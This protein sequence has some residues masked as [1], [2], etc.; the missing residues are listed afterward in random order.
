MKNRPG[1]KLWTR[2]AALVLAL[3]LCGAWTPSARAGGPREITMRVGETRTVYAP[4]TTMETNN[5][6]WSS[7]SS[8]VRVSGSGYSCTATAVQATNL[9]VLLTHHY[10]KKLSSGIS[11]PYTQD[12]RVK[13]LPPL[14]QSVSLYPGSV[15]L[16]AGEGRQLTASVSPEG[17][18]YG[19][20][21]WSSDDTSV[22]TVTSGGYVRAV[23]PGTTWINVRT[24]MEG[25]EDYCR[26]TVQ[27]QRYK[28]TFDPGEGSV[29]PSSR[30]VT[31]GEPYGE[32]PVPVREGY[33]FR[34]WYTKA[35]GGE[36]AS[37]E[38]P[39]EKSHTL[40]ARWRLKGLD[41][42]ARYM[43]QSGAEEDGGFYMEGAYGGKGAGTARIIYKE[44]SGQPAS[45]TFLYTMRDGT[46]S[47]DV[48]LSLAE[49]AETAGV[50]AAFSGSQNGE[51][52]TF[53]CEGTLAA[54][55]YDGKAA[56]DF[57][58]I[59]GYE[60]PSDYN[61][62]SNAGLDAAAAAWELLLAE[63]AGLSLRDLGFVSYQ[64]GQENPPPALIVASGS[65]GTGVTWSLDS[66]G[67]LEIA[68][69]GVMTN[70]AMGEAPWYG[71]RESVK[72][73]KTGGVRNIGD[74]AFYGCGELTEAEVSDGASLVGKHAFDG[75]G[76]LREVSLPSGLTGIGDHAFDSAGLAELTVPSTVSV[77]GE[78]A[79]YHC[80]GLSDVTVEDGV[81]SI[82]S[83]AFCGCGN[84]PG[85]VLPDSVRELGAYAFKDCGALSEAALS[86][87]ILYLNDGVFQDCVLLRSIH[88]PEGVREIGRAGLDGAFSGCT[89]LAAASIPRSVTAIGAGSFHN[90]WNLQIHYSGTKAEWETV[91]ID[92]GEN[93]EIDP[94]AVTYGGS[95]VPG[96][97]TV[98]SWKGNQAVFYGPLDAGASLF[99]VR[100]DGAG[101]MVRIASGMAEGNTVTFRNITLAAKDQIFVLSGEGM[102]PQAS[103]AILE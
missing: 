4:I 72:A 54:A 20:Y 37:A 34:G 76:R 44:V 2:L 25:K 74:Y 51:A 90:C 3:A 94:A 46:A 91:K 92:Y 29:S 26:V 22:A 31:G 27:A 14:P 101:R 7:N 77:I 32:L 68:G 30:T 63:K 9:T 49:N 1:R 23:G 59:D 86:K 78:F 43:E 98:Q 84:L 83:S 65:C 70:Y 67:L 40:Y 103:A 85:I 75:C 66:G 12:V 6:H 21:L 50:T 95:A 47:A 16:N 45:L 88:I 96:P 8:A 35:E 62:V 73:L 24:Q 5:G 19:S 53:A 17:A 69:T 89:S 36:A 79:F 33:V 80:T 100:Y 41:T 57:R 61:S 15:T 71:C 58:Q 81:K 10:T 99:A 13:V 52:G 55:S 11:M 87:N 48:E 38:T 93:P 97:W 18:D 82:G 42:L 39:V 64:S 56:V 60:Y 102:T 28:V